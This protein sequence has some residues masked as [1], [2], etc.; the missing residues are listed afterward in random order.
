MADA[1]L[2]ERE[3]AEA[4]AEEASQKAQE[5]ARAAELAGKACR[6]AQEAKEKALARAE[7][8]RKEAEQIRAKLSA[9]QE[10]IRKEAEEIQKQKE[11]AQRQ[12]DEAQKSAKAAEEA[13]KKLQEKRQNEKKEPEAETLEKGSIFSSQG[14]RYRVTDAVK[15][16]VT[17]L[18]AEQKNKKT[19]VIPAKAGYK[20]ET[21]KVTAI[22]K[23]AFW[24]N[25]KLKTVTIG[26][27]VQVIGK[28]AFYQDTNLKSIKVQSRKL[29]KVGKKAFQ[30]I[31]KKALIQVKGKEKRANR[32]KIKKSK[33][34]G[35]V[36]IQ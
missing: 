28:Q 4:E 14:L 35:V 1:S 6:E 2:E 29:T 8:F 24:K 23:K 15:K 19:L 12:R 11:E 33:L 34:S 17:V 9:V 18:G 25:K 10:E 31:S 30:G 13:L 26:K 21:Y 7:S 3:K 5:A 20:G 36:R 22:E 16:T 32:E 27:N